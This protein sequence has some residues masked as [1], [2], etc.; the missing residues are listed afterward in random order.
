[1]IEALGGLIDEDP[2]VLAGHWVQD[3]G[4]AYEL[5]AHDAEDREWREFLWHPRRYPWCVSATS[6]T[7][8]QRGDLLVLPQSSAALL[9]LLWRYLARAEWP[10]RAGLA[11]GPL[12]VPRILYGQGGESL[13]IETVHATLTVAVTPARAAEFELANPNRPYPGRQMSLPSDPVEALAAVLVW[14]AEHP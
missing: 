10:G 11:L 1:V 4:G 8:A 12:D 9:R 3:A 7:L 6:Q 5:C 13:F 2:P 14:L